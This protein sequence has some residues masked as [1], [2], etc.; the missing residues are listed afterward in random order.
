MHK[1]I[2]IDI[3]GSGIMGKG[4]FPFSLTPYAKTIKNNNSW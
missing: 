1:E 3:V 2:E 4:L